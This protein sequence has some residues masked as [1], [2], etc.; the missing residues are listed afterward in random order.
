MKLLKEL[1]LQDIQQVLSLYIGTVGPSAKL[2]NETLLENVA[3][4]FECIQKERLGSFT[5]GS[6]W[7]PQSN[8]VVMQRNDDRIYFNFHVN[9]DSSDTTVDAEKYHESIAKGEEFVHKVSL[10]F[11]EDAQGQLLKFLERE[12]I[13]VKTVEVSYDG[14]ADV[15]PELKILL[16]NNAFE[17]SEEKIP[18]MFCGYTVKTILL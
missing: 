6:K 16:S 5:L 17:E 3:F 10:F 9:F 8:L 13:N 2:T 1:N 11:L 4:I 7:C 15:Y 18:I 12:G 14:S